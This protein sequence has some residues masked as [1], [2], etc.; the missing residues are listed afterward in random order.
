MNPGFSMPTM[1]RKKTAL[2]EPS[3][4]SWPA[5]LEVRLLRWQASKI[6]IDFI[7]DKIYS[8]ADRILLPSVASNDRAPKAI[9]G[10]QPGVKERAIRKLE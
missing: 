6:L 3:F 7:P 10:A 5:C 4:V 9:E 2:H 1:F 8:N